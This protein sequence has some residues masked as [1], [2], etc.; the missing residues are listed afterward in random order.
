[1]RKIK[2]MSSKEV[3]AKLEEM[4]PNELFDSKDWKASNLVGRVEWLLCMFNSKE[5]EIKSLLN[6]IENMGEQMSK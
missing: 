5:N 2:K 3:V 1:M 4:L 6:Q